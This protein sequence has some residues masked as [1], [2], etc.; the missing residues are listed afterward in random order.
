MKPKFIKLAQSLLE[1]SLNVN[2]TTTS[3]LDFLKNK[4]FEV[5]LNLTYNLLSFH[6]LQRI[7]SI[8]CDPKHGVHVSLPY[9]KFDDGFSWYLIPHSFYC[10]K[11]VFLFYVS[12]TL[13]LRVS[14]CNPN[15][16]F[17]KVLLNTKFG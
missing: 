15:R 5:H 16:G 3:K 4:S 17:H 14:K 2:N 8:N 9:S 10:P 12:V 13:A 7:I 6:R 11:T 1:L